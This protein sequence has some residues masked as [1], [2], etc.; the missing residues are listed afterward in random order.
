M[1]RYIEEARSQC[2]AIEITIVMG[3]L[4]AKV[5]CGKVGST[6]GPHGIG[7]RK[8]AEDEEIDGWSGAS[9]QHGHHEY[10]V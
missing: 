1:T 2:Q 4:N 6:V 10:V 3:D 7:V 8:I 9:K 5:G